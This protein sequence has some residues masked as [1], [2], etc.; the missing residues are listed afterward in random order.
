M[1]NYIRPRVTGA[2]IF[3]TVTLADRGS[4]L[5]VREIGR[6]REAVRATR[7]ERAF[8]IDAWVVLPD[9]LHCVWTLP[10]GDRDFATRWGAIKARFT[11]S[12]R[13][14]A[15]VGSYAGRVGRVFNPPSSEVP[16]R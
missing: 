5:L 7:A 16:A 13:D 9:H 2:R 14:G 15:A 4:D 11:R 8:G 3:F 1:P 12:L 10:E 6:L